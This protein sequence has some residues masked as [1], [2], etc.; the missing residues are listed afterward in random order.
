MANLKFENVCIDSYATE[1]PEDVVKTDVRGEAE[2]KSG[3]SHVGA[4]HSAG[5]YDNEFLVS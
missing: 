1:I 5:A 3:L 4:D 2:H